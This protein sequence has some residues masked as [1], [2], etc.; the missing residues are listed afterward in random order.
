MLRIFALLAL[1]AATA[2]VGAFAV[3]QGFFS[4]PESF[5]FLVPHSDVDAAVVAFILE[6]ILVVAL[7]LLASESPGTLRRR[8]GALSALFGFLL[9]A[10]PAYVVLVAFTEPAMWIRVR[11]TDRAIEMRRFL[12]R[13]P[14]TAHRDLAIESLRRIERSWLALNPADSAVRTVISL[15]ESPSRRVLIKYMPDR[16]FERQTPSHLTSTTASSYRYSFNEFDEEATRLLRGFAMQLS[17]EVVFTTDAAIP[18]TDTTVLIDVSYTARFGASNYEYFGTGGAGR[19][20]PVVL[21]LQWSIYGP[22]QLTP[23]RRLRQDFGPDLRP[24]WAGQKE[25]HVVLAENLLGKV[26][27]VLTTEF[28]REVR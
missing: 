27:K 8:G 11:D 14:E 18:V 9:T 19:I 6:V 24:S 1:G 2:A 5:A 25:M 13:F 26:K 22:G 21:G 4:A 15:V 16:V 12:Q 20:A 7:L 28:T 10:V 17:S 23:A 3:G